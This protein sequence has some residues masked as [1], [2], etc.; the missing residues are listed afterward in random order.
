MKKTMIRFFLAVLALMLI[1]IGFNRIDARALAVVEPLPPLPAG[2]FAPSNGY[3]R[4]WTLIEP[5]TVDVETEAAILP[6]RR[7]FDPAFDNDK[8]IGE[9]DQEKYKSK[10]RLPEYRKEYNFLSRTNWEWSQVL[11]ARAPLVRYQTEYPFM[12]DRYERM[13]DCER[14]VDFTTMRVDAPIP[15]L[16]AW[17]HHVRASVA[18]DILRAHDGDWPGAAA[19]L[20]RHLRFA[21]RAVRGSRMLITNLVGKAAARQI[22]WGL[23]VL[24]NQK[25]CPRE[26]VQAIFSSTPPLSYGEFG[27]EIPFRAEAR[28][29]MEYEFQQKKG[30]FQLLAYKLF[31]QKNRTNNIRERY[32][33]ELIT[34][35]K[36]PPVQ[37]D[38]GSLREAPMHAS[39]AFWWLQNPVGKKLLDAFGPNFMTVIYKSYALK[40]HYDMVH[41][42]A[43]LHLHY[44]PSRPIGE[45]LDRLASYQ[46]LLDL[47]S[48]KPYKWD[49][50]KQILYSIGIDRVD[51]GGETLDFSKI[52]GSDYTL[53]V[54]LYMK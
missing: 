49:E 12:F 4:L 8:F 2:A 47:C 27:S 3:Y 19:H 44:D 15:N 46:E 33:K 28:I 11:T 6:Y 16:L 18:L 54:I 24:M 39:G 25:E 30:F 31:Y 37:W 34:L 10:F 9:W 21:N 43:D 41:I 32:M 22:L 5:E 45:T 7:L 26:L 14:F 36:T 38:Q 40:A 29:P 48:G 42:A 23:N 17:L 1:Y 13:T 35:E 53:P 51:N 52:R 50:A 20:L